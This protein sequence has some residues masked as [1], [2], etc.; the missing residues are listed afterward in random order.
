DGMVCL[1]RGGHELD[2]R[3]HGP[4]GEA[5]RAARRAL[6]RHPG[7][8]DPRTMAG[9]TT[10]LEKELA[11]LLEQER[12]EPPEEFKANALIKDMSVHEEA[13]KDPVGWWRAQADA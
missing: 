9:T 4:S 5:P 1:V 6:T 3:T 10:D 7:E 8:G 2:V 13:A 12:F 11:E